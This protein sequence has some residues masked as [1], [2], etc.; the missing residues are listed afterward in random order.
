MH[1]G[2]YQV[3]LSMPL[4]PTDSQAFYFRVNLENGR[5]LTA[6]RGSEHSAITLYYILEWL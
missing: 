2:Q 3:P 5:G 6:A 4:P 1:G